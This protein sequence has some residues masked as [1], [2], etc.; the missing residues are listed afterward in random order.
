MK[1][2]KLNKHLSRC[3]EKSDFTLTQSK[4]A[5]SIFPLDIMAICKRKQYNVLLRKLHCHCFCPKNI[6]HGILQHNLWEVH[7]QR[8]VALIFLQKNI[9]LNL[10]IFFP[11]NIFEN[12][13]EPPVLHKKWPIY[14]SKKLFIQTPHVWKIHFGP[15]HLSIHHT[16]FSALWRVI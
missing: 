6:N 4:F 15:F 2:Q 14:T 8:F 3:F 11:E 5:I 12:F 16:W 9:P 1:A 13:Y 7:G 10:V